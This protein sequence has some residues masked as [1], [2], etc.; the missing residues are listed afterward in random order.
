MCHR[1]IKN[2]CIATP[3]PQSEPGLSAKDMTGFGRREKLLRQLSSLENGPLADLKKT[4][5]ERMHLL[6]KASVVLDKLVS[7]ATA[8][9]LE[10]K[11]S[12]ETAAEAKD[13][14]E[15]SRERVTQVG[16]ERAAS[17]DTVFTG[18]WF[19]AAYSSVACL[20]HLS[21]DSPSLSR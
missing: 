15:A 19:K 10:M 8:A 21:I 6:A 4:N 7:T 1:L 12:D 13:I 14:L 17:V 9:Q 20:S 16:G 18:H 3:L 11:R 2:A 5:T